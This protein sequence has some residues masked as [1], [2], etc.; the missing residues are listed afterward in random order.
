MP[1]EDHR[2]KQFPFASIATLQKALEA[3]ISAR[4]PQDEETSIATPKARNQ[5]GKELYSLVFRCHLNHPE[6][7]LTMAWYVHILQQTTPQPPQIDTANN[8]RL[9]HIVLIIV[10][11]YLCIYVSACRYADI[12]SSSGRSLFGLA[13]RPVFLTHP[14]GCLALALA[15][16]CA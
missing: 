6:Q 3:R 9:V 12:H 13:F 10:S 2:R 4:T 15:L 16:P 11:I 8:K 5:P 1:P 14:P 7:T